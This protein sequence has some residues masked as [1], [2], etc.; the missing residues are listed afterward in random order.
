MLVLEMVV[1]DAR[2]VVSGLRVGDQWF[3]SSI[4]CRYCVLSSFSG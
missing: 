4:L 2:S 1:D 3:G